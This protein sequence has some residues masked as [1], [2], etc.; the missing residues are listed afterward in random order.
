MRPV[1]MGPEGVGAEFFDL[2]SAETADDLR[3]VLVLYPPMRNSANAFEPYV[4]LS[5]H[6]KIDPSSTAVTAML[7]VTDTRWSGGVGNLIRRIEQSGMVDD[8]E[9]DLLAESFLA[10]GD[11]LFWEV[12]DEWFG[13]EIVITIDDADPELVEDEDDDDE[14][15]TVARRTVH[16][17]LRRWAAGRLVGGEPERWGDV[18]KRAGDL[19]ARA[20]A[21]I[22]AG[23]LDVI[24]GLP[25]A[26]QDFLINEAVRW[27]NHSVRRQ[28][29]GLVAQRKG[30]EAAHAIAVADPSAG[31]RAWA[32]SLLEPPAQ[33]RAAASPEAPAPK[34]RPPAPPTLF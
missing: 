6:H 19:D 13:D 31:V 5:K 3:R 18:Y 24:D 11:A 32:P 29:I 30:T 15:P 28:A 7:M 4:L 23:L 12:P 16:P 26:T 22:V 8:V 33:P 14:R 25:T 10:A 1:E 20:A 27:P 34:E 21:A 2:W 17:P 9:L